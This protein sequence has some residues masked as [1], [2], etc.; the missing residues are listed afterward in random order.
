MKINFNVVMKDWK[1]EPVTVR[2]DKSGEDKPVLISEKIQELLYF[3]GGNGQV[4]NEKKYKAHKV[5]KKFER[6]EDEFSTE[7]LAL[8]KEVA[9]AGLISGVVGQVYDLIEDNREESTKK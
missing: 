1:G 9:G 2:D 4:S 3:Y 8:I 7:E 6:G 5:R